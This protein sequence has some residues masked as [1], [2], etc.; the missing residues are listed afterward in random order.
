MDLSMHRS[1]VEYALTLLTRT[2]GSSGERA[3]S[4]EQELQGWRHEAPEHEHAFQ[5]ARLRW[6]TLDAMAGDL[7]ALLPEPRQRRS[8]LSAW[9]WTALGGALASLT[10][11]CAGWYYLVPVAEQSFSTATAQSGRYE[12]RDGSTLE[13]NAES[14]VTVRFYRQRRE[15]ELLAGEARFHVKPQSGQS[16]RVTA[17]NVRATVLGTIF[18]VGHRG[19]GAQV[20]V[21][22]GVVRVD[23]RRPWWHPDVQGPSLRAGQQVHGDARGTEAVRGLA[24]TQAA[25]WRR[26]LAVFDDTPLTEAVEQ[27][28]PWSPLPLMVADSSAASQ[29]ITGTFHLNDIPGMLDLLPRIAPVM[30]DR[31]A[32]GVTIRSLK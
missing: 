1:H 16:F 24:E 17:G 11:A 25:A 30:V 31:Q 22:E 15:A 8:F 7:R 5:E 13:L 29:R 32:S 9:R 20:Q 21:E 2:V 23:A 4:A 26:G 18:T 12:L 14:K 19:D 6:Q 28:Q 10:I 27:L 3:R